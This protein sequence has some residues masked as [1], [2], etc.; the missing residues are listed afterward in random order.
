[1]SDSKSNALPTS[2]DINLTNIGINR[3][4]LYDFCLLYL[5]CSAPLEPRGLILLSVVTKVC[6]STLLA[7]SSAGEKLP[8]K[9]FLYFSFV[10]FLLTDMWKQSF[11]LSVI[12]QLLPS[13][14]YLL[15]C[16]TAQFSADLLQQSRYRLHLK[17][18]YFVSFSSVLLR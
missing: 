18:K 15:V 16:R 12:F 13:A 5:L 3:R 11:C 6:K 17:N 14:L 9:V 8:L 1:M 7:N 10:F 4:V 2:N